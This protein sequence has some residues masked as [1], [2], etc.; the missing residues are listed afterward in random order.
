[1]HSHAPLRLSNVGPTAGTDEA[2]KPRLS[3]DPFNKVVPVLRFVNVVVPAVRLAVARTAT[4]LRHDDIASAS[5]LHADRSAL[6]TGATIG[7]THRNGRRPR[8][9]GQVDIRREPKSIA[10]R[11]ELS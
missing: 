9:W 3:R 4:V 5:Q 7:S 8:C 10:H 6:V 1:M 11:D 2:V